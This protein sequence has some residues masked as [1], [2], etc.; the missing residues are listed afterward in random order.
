LGSSTLLKLDLKFDQGITEIEDLQN[1][2][3]WDLYDYL[4]VSIMSHGVSDKFITS[5]FR[6][7]DIEEFTE[8]FSGKRFPGLLGKP[9]R[10]IATDKK[11][12]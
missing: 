2:I 4:V 8:E 1:N 11:A 5:D 7:Y 12:I 3:N 10:T 9:S 6:E